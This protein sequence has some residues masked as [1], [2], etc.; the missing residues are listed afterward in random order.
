MSVVLVQTTIN[1][2]FR[3]LNDVEWEILGTHL[4]F[5][6]SEIRDIERDHQNT[7]RRRI[8]LFDLWLKKEQDPSWVKMIAALEEMSENNLASRLRKKY[9]QQPQDKNPQTTTCERP[10]P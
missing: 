9:Q 8:V 10:I 2:L 3:E 5:S 6:Q 7:A 4:G 1:V